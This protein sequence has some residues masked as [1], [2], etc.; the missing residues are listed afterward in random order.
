[1][2]KT[3]LNKTKALSITLTLALMLTLAGCKSWYVPMETP[4]GEPVYSYIVK[5]Y[6]PAT[7]KT[8]EEEKFTTEPMHPVT[9]APLEVVRSDVLKPGF[10]VFATIGSILAGI[11]PATAPFAPLIPEAIT[12]V[13]VAGV[14]LRG[15]RKIDLSKAKGK[16]MTDLSR[17]LMEGYDQLKTMAKNGNLSMEDIKDV[18]VNKAGE[19][20]DP[21]LLDQLVDIA[22]SALPKTEKAKQMDAAL[23]EFLKNN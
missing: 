1:M 2:N 19:F 18:L 12:L 10:G 8:T 6:D 13:G 5:N 22:I 4:N 14:A 16:D 21:E 3:K 20:K 23:E 15:R 11:F 7:G 17:I 9:K